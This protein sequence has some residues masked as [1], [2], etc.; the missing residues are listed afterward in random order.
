MRLRTLAAAG[1]TTILLAGTPQALNE[2]EAFVLSS[3]E[4]AMIAAGKIEDMI[5]RSVRVTLAAIDGPEL[6][7]K[8]KDT[9]YIRTTINPKGSKASTAFGRGLTESE[10][11]T[12]RNL[13]PQP[14][15]TWGVPRLERDGKPVVFEEDY[16]I[17]KERIYERMDYK[18]KKR[19]NLKYHI[20]YGEEAEMTPELIEAYERTCERIIES[21]LFE[22]HF[23][24]K[25][26]ISN[27]RWGKG[28]TNRLAKLGMDF[29]TDNPKYFEIAYKILADSLEV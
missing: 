22:N 14:N 18:H 13:L 23:D 29:A 20:D 3:L 4:G 24:A 16:V 2:P 28:K 12:Y 27:W 25:R 11:E 21:K 1:L 5:K 6:G 17:L 9:P 7:E 8:Y 10:L 26:V 19:G 15:G